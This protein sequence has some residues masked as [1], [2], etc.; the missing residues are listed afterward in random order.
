MTE[1]KF[2]AMSKTDS[3]KHNTKAILNKSILIILF[4]FIIKLIIYSVN[5]I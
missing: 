4:F 3:G 5:N 1:N 2:L